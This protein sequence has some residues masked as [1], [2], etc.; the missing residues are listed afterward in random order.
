V[1][2][3]YLTIFAVSLSIGVIISLVFSLGFFVSWRAKLT[4]KLFLQGEPSQEIIIIAIDND[5]LQELGRWPWD[6]AVHAQLIDKINEQEPMVIGLDVSFPEKSSFASDQELALAITRAGN[7]VLPIESELSFI[8]QKI[9]SN[10]ILW[11]IE[12]IRSAAIGLGITNTPP[13]QDGVFRKLPLNVYTQEDEKY[14][15]FAVKIAD[16]YT[17]GLPPIPTDQ[18]ERMIVNYFGRPGTISAIPAIEVMNQELEPGLLKDKI[19]LIGAT[20]PDLHDEQ[21]TPVSAGQP[22]SGVEIH[23]NA[24]KTILDNRFLSPLNIYWQIIILIGLALVIGFVLTYFRLIIASLISLAVLIVYLIT[25]LVIFDRG[26]ILDIFYP[27]VVFV[28][29]YTLVVAWRYLTERKEKQQIKN[30][31]SRYVS[32][33]VIN[34]ILADPDKLGLGGQEREITLL[35]SDIRG[36]TSISEKLSP[37]QLVKLMN[38][39]LTAMTDLIMESGGVVDKYIGDAIMAF[40]GAPL[41]EPDHPAKACQVALDM[42][43]KLE[44]ERQEWQKEF[45]VEI[46]IGVGINTGPVII[47]NIGS[48]K[49]FDYTAMGDTVNLASRLEGLNKEYGT[50]IIISQFTHE[51]VKDKFKFR[52]I[53][54]VAVKGKEEKVGIYQLL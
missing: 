15:A 21:I 45:G 22:M 6:R 44:Q 20:A 38:K 29:T 28:L 1:K 7:V 48:S 32:P 52:Y 9:I 16:F 50:E 12:S 24:I 49:R 53:D 39:Y 14:S 17:G 34:E 40:W 18:Q 3:N 19:V 47:G 36:F 42:I 4:D 41:E 2:K 35:F 5:S 23:A 8:K 31:F 43:K 26:I 13:D 10:N 25:A 51:K 54:K 46:K 30:A 11:P 33:D 27:L 37:E